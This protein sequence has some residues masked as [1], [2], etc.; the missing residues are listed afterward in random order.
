MTRSSQDPIVICV[1]PN[2]AR[3]QRKDHPGIPLSAD[4]L[5]YEAARCRDAGAAMIHLHVRDAK[6]GH[7]LDADAYLDV[8]QAIRREVGDGLVIQITTESVGKYHPAEQIAVVKAVRPEAASVALRELVPNEDAVGE[9]EAFYHDMAHKGVMAQH[10]LYSPQEVRRFNGLRARGVIPGDK[11]LVL[12]VL[13]SYA[14]GPGHVADLKAYLG[15]L[16]EGGPCHWGV[17]AFGVTEAQAAR[18]AIENGGHPRVGFEN[19]LMLETGIMASNNA[20]LVA[21]I[22]EDAQ[23][24]E[25][26]IA[27]AKA[28]WALF[29]GEKEGSTSGNKREHRDAGGRNR[30]LPCVGAA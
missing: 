27:D 19:N 23:L 3:R 7:L 26:T 10:I 28:A 1:A 24:S 4:E 17:C 6:G 15:A 29:S 18:W 30:R 25:R 5:A 9:A 16:A 21:Q 22:V 8:T 20:A 11:P 2:G 12:F 14:G 13:G